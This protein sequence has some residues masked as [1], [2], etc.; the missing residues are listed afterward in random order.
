MSN[1]QVLLF[2]VGGI[3]IELGGIEI[4]K[5]LT[6]Q[7]DE[8]DMWRRWLECQVVKDFESGRSSDTDFAQDMVDKYDLDISTDFFVESFAQWPKG[9]YDGAKELVADVTPDV[10]AGC[11][12]NTNKIHWSNPLNQGVHALFDLHFLSFEM[13]LVKPDPSAFHYVVD[14]LDCAPEDI[15][16]VDDNI[17]NVDAARACGFDAH[18]A[19]GPVETRQVLRNHG[20]LK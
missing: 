20:L 8:A 4:W 11:F 19:K 10:K 15:F 7:T 2:D 12:S 14:A 17:I 16:F 3:L 13:G 18:V 5:N 9:F 6:G 1:I